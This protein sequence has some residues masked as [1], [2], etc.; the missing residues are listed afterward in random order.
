PVDSFDR[1]LGLESSLERSFDRVFKSEVFS[2]SLYQLVPTTAT[3]AVPYLILNATRVENGKR[4]TMGPIYF[5]TD[6]SSGRDDWHAI[7]YL[8]APSVAVAALTSA[9]F[10]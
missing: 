4:V 7:D 2:Q 8:E 3:P 1:Q 10:P 5:E 9:R 6:L